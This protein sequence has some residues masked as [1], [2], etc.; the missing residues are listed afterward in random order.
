MIV[1][2]FKKCTILNKV[3]GSEDDVIYKDVDDEFIQGL[4][5]QY[6]DCLEWRRI[7]SLIY[8]E[9]HWRILV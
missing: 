9:W 3:D 5:D 4:D 1:K 6:D 8:S 2:A 7:Q